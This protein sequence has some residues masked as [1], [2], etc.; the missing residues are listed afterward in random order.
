MSISVERDGQIHN[1]TLLE[2]LGV[3]TSSQV[4]KCKRE[5]EGKEE[6]FVI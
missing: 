4:F 3:G 2:K 6:I 1:Y 5:V